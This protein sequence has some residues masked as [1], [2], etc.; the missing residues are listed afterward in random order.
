MRIG[1]SYQA[2]ISL[3]TISFFFFFPSFFSESILRKLIGDHNGYEVKVQGDSFI[4][5]FADPLDAIKWSLMVQ[6]SLLDYSYVID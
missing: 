3:K 1:N 2:V 4:V 5:V 6:E